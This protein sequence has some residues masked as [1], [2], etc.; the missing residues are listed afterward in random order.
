MP[1]I[2]LEPFNVLAAYISSVDVANMKS[3]AGCRSILQMWNHKGDETSL[4]LS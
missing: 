3:C 2:G 1:F 4:P